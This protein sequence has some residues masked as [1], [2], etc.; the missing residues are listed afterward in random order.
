MQEQTATH[1]N[2]MQQT[3]ANKQ[4]VKHCQTMH[5]QHTT[6]AIHCSPIQYIPVARAHSEAIHHNTTL[7]HNAAHCSTLQNTATRTLTSRASPPIRNSQHYNA[8]THRN[9]L[10]HTPPQRQTLQHTLTSRACPPLIKTID[11]S[12]SI[13]RNPDTATYCNTLQHNTKYC[14]THTDQPHEPTLNKNNRPLVIHLTQSRH[15]NT[16]HHT[17]TQYKTLQH[18]H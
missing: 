13:S 12:R 10:Q 5:H 1:C 16:P 18:T 9:T 14:N 3:L 17:A 11:H 15:C 6:P 8:A 2:T 7:Q 4:T